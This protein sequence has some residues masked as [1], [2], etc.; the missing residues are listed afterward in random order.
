MN[1]KPPKRPALGRGLGALLPPVPAAAPVV[2]SIPSEP[3][4][5]GVPRL[6]PIEALQPSADQPRKRFD[7]ELLEQLAAS[8]R[9]Q[10]IIQPIVVSPMAQPSHDGAR[11]VIIAGERRWRAA[12]LAGLHDVPVVVRDS[13]E[14]QRLEL[15][16][17]ENLQRAELN[18]IEEA[19]AF[20]ELLS[21][22]GYTQEQL[23]ER[24]GKDRSTVANAMRLL[25]L[26]ERVQEMVRDG[27]LSM[28]HARALLGLERES[29]IAEV[30][31]E[32]VRGSWSVRAVE[33]AVR[34]KVVETRSMPRP[35][36]EDADRRRIIVTELEHRLQRRLGSRV[37]LRTDARKRGA[38]VVEIPYA[39]LDELDRL[40]HI[41]LDDATGFGR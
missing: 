32:A 36:D 21:I 24:V 29:E 7:P 19:R 1:A 23:A 16:L 4:V 41:L 33:R 28:G 3:A 27:R 38:G 18:P 13:D 22:R 26:P 10:G 20:A 14:Q 9:A 35:A 40:L 34:A 2:A 31:Q 8:I 15:A 37:R 11:Y 17:V 30:A 5:P 6:L 39:S 12:Q 25:R